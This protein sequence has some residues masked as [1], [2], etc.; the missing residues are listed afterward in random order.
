M[1]KACNSIYHK[2]FSK[3]DQVEIEALSKHGFI[4]NI[5]SQESRL[6]PRNFKLDA[7]Y[8]LFSS[9]SMLSFDEQICEK[10]VLV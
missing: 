5:R 1:S 4:K 10:V 9:K 8:W 3:V 7:L 2:M 6:P